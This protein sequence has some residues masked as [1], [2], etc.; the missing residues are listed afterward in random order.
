MNAKETLVT[1]FLPQLAENRQARITAVADDEIG[2]SRAAGNR[3]WLIQPAFTDRGLDIVIKRI[4]D[5]TRVVFVGP[6]LLQSD[7]HRRVD[8][9][10]G[11]PLQFWTLREVVLVQLV[12]DLLLTELLHLNNLR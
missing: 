2:F 1:G 8:E 3:R 9:W 12:G 10:I 7:Q 6:Q 4:T 11:Q 5:K